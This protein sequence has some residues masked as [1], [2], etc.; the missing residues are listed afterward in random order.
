MGFCYSFH[1]FWV[2]GGYLWGLLGHVEASLGGLGAFP[3]AWEEPVGKSKRNLASKRESLGSLVPPLGAPGCPFAAPGTKK[4]RRSGQKTILGQHGSSDICMCFT[5][6]S[7][8][9]DPKWTIWGVLWLRMTT[10]G[11]MWAPF[12][13]Q[14]ALW[15]AIGCPNWLLF[16]GQGRSR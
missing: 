12:W 11:H 15:S 4:R 10:F 5:V 14:V 13:L 2:S 9:G 3:A 16:R 1:V 6:F 8:V 7:E